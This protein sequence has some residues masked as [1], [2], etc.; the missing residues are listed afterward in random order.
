MS[1][2]RLLLLACAVTSS[3]GLS[4]PASAEHCKWR[5]D[6]AFSLLANQNLR[7]LDRIRNPAELQAKLEANVDSLFGPRQQQCEEGAYSLFLERYERYALEALRLS[8]PERDLRLR[9]ATSVIRKGPEIV[10]YTTASRETTLFRQ[11]AVNISAVAQDAGMSPIMRQLVDAIE[12]VGP[13]KATPRAAAA[14]VDPH[15]AMVYV[16]TVP[17]PGWAVVSLY[18]MEDHAR[19]NEMGALQGKIEAIL[20]WMKTVTPTT[21]P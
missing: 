4:Q 6:H 12:A 5:F 21:Q 20:T 14:P 19:R 9:I 17:L 3:L 16:P 1:R 8:G 10:D 15:I 2:A 13:P 7:G 11:T 18:E